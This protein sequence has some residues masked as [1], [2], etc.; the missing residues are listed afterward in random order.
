MTPEERA[1]SLAKA[2]L[3]AWSNIG[4][5]WA[6]S[7][8]VVILVALEPVGGQP[9]VVLFREH[10]ALEAAVLSMLSQLSACSQGQIV[11]VFR[12][13]QLLRAVLVTD[14]APNPFEAI[15]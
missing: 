13:G 2:E 8:P 4:G 14:A 12:T 15:Q 9:P 11:A 1:I 5:D 6:P 7:A 10:D 3:S